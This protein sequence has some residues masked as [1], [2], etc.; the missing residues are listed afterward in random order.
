MKVTIHKK[1]LLGFIGTIT[2]MVLSSVYI[3]LELEQVKDAAKI[4]LSSNVKSIDLAKQLKTILYD[5]EG[6][7]QKFL[8][9][10][11]RMY[12]DLYLENSGRFDQLLADLQRLQTDENER[13]L[14]NNLASTHEWLVSSLVDEIRETGTDGQARLT[15]RWLDTTEL[16]HRTIDHLI[17]INQLSIGNAMSNV[18]TI[19][20][21]SARVAL[22]LT[23]CTFILALSIAAFIARTITRPISELIKGTARFATASFEPVSVS[24]EDEI[25]LLADAFNDMGGKLHK[26]N[27][28]KAE[29]MGQISHEL[30]TP[31]QTLLIAHDILETERLGEL[32]EKQRDVLVSIHDSV[33]MISNFSN[34]YLDIAKVEAGMMQYAPQL[35]EIEKIMKKA[36]DETKL[37]AERKDVT[38]H[39]EV[40]K[41][42]A[43]V[44]V[45][46]EKIGIVFRNLLN[47]AIKY[48][49]EGSEVDVK[50]ARSKFGVKI[51]VSDN[52][53]GI[54]EEELPH[55]FTRFYQALNSGK[56]GS[57]GIG[58]GL[59]IVKAFT[60]GHGGRVEVKS[61]LDVGS[62]FIVEL[63]PAPKELLLPQESLGVHEASY[64]QE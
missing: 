11:D 22:F 39:L 53:I 13:S 9:S 57:K 28:Y 45:D 3:L 21:R 48:S 29:M 14:T 47:N 8:I 46:R 36:V 19:A 41:G 42:V 25:S 49:P 35:T 26:M 40:L 27:E 43:P 38:V 52:G 61:S 51:T 31:L 59:A 24:S 33:D 17:G 7:A 30:K 63:P 18:D 10:Q 5:E 6:Y 37:L 12:Y 34:Q 58:L 2:L 55:V 62:T 23:A 54:A 4:T 56:T 20:N 15:N 16:L 50:I 1:I 44:S 60:E 32:N 64:A